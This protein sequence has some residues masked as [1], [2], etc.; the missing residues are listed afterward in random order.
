MRKL[1]YFAMVSLDGKIETTDRSLEWVVI[2]EELHRYLNKLEREAGEYLYGRRMYELMHPYW[3]TAGTLS[4]QAV[5]REF[6]VIWKQI[7]KI[8][9][10]QTLEK[11]EGNA[12]LVR[13]DAV[14][15]VTRLKSQPGGHL[16]VG[17][18]ELAGSLMHAGLIDE[19]RLF[20]Q[21]VIL[22]AGTPI[23]TPVNGPVKL[24]LAEQHPFR[25]GVVYLRYL[26]EGEQE[27]TG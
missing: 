16:E 19:Y 10:S 26:V 17:G 6:S 21:P 5:E 11:V 7:P 1:I 13:T 23:I 15:E 22:G 18:A 27:Q 8:V 4:D 14:E 12:T 25:S 3:S 20:V 9:F 24:R 2:D